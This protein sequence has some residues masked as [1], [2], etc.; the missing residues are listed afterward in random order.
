MNPYDRTREIVSKFPG[1][2]ERE[3]HG[4]KCFFLNNK[5]PLCY[6][7]DNHR[8][9]GRISIWCPL[10]EGD[11]ADLVDNDPLHYFRP[12]TSSSGAFS[13]WVGLYLDVNGNEIIDWENVSILIE[14]A[15]RHIAPKRI[16]EEYDAE[17]QSR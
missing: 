5:K 15:F 14:E 7:H 3:S 2:H 9:D 12:T 13:N 11:A 4:A 8:G 6:F 1:I 16:V 10:A 17:E